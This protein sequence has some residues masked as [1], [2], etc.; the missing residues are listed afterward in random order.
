MKTKLFFQSLAV[1]ALLCTA[2]VLPPACGTDGPGGPCSRDGKACNA[3]CDS[4]LGCV[5][6]A[7]D[8]DCGAAA[9]FCVTGH[10]EECAGPGDCGAA[11]ACWPGKNEC[12]PACGS[13]ADCPGDA[14][15]CD[16]DSGACVECI[17]DV[18][19]PNDHPLCSPAHGTCVDCTGNGDCGA[20]KPVCDVDDGRCKECIIDA[21]CDAGLCDGG[22][23]CKAGCESDS[24]CPSERPFCGDNFQCFECVSD[25][26]CGAA[27][28]FCNGKNE[29]GQCLVAADCNDLPGT[30]FCLDSE[31]CVE[32]IDKDDCLNGDKCKDHRCE[33]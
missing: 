7:G 16:Q 19:C 13:N 27:K 8:G 1:A 4:T 3:I 28:P 18:D 24:D 33:P 5:D 11:Q 10:C 29:C 15:L 30:P 26:D 31:S 23:N 6:C 20:A 14:K 25:G 32:C 9:P 21:H 2:V 22:G 17:E 12:H